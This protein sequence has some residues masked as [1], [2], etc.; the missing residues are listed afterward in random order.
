MKYGIGQCQAIAKLTTLLLN[1]PRMNVNCRIARTG[2][3]GH[4]FNI[5]SLEDGQQYIIDN[6]W[7]ITRNPNRHETYLRTKSFSD[8]NLLI[9]ERQISGDSHHKHNLDGNIAEDEF[10][11]DEIQKSIR[12]LEE[13]GIS[14]EYGHT[15]PLIPQNKVYERVRDEKER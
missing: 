12:K 8:C 2:G 5:V 13:L 4:S 7:C 3:N 14:F 6:T 15:P 11:R 10:S 1:N 9:G